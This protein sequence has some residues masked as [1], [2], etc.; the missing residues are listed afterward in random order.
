MMM[1]MILFISLLS[2]NYSLLLRLLVMLKK[3]RHSS[4][5]HSPSSA[6]EIDTKQRRVSFLSAFVVLFLRR[7]FDDFEARLRL[8]VRQF[9]VL[10]KTLNFHFCLVERKKNETSLGKKRRKRTRTK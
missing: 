5:Q 10:V 2:L 7:D 6:C 9:R 4:A 3:E 1:E 8:G